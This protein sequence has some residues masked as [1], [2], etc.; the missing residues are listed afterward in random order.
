MRFFLDKAH[1]IGI[2]RSGLGAQHNTARLN[3]LPYH[4]AP[5]PSGPLPPDATA[6]LFASPDFRFSF[7]RVEHACPF[8]VFPK[9]LGPPP[10]HPLSTPSCIVSLPTF[11]HFHGSRR[12]L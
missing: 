7:S 2:P 5:R 6:A 8:A 12:N 11:F 9:D 4:L 10:V 3:S 1:S